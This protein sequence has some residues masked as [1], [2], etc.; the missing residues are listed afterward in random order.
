MSITLRE[1]IMLMLM[2]TLGN[3]GIFCRKLNGY[4]PPP[5]AN[6]YHMITLSIINIYQISSS[7]S[8][9]TQLYYG[10]TRYALVTPLINKL[11][12]TAEDVTSI[13]QSGSR[14]N[15]PSFSLAQNFN[16]YLV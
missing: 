1:K 2:T 12:F 6:I 16:Y 11:Q 14:D 4:H 13:I 5:A 7:L 15:D 8:I 9:P 3:P 10:N